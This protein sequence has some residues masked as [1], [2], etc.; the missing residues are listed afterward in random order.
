MSAPTG[1]RHRSLSG[2][3]AAACLLYSGSALNVGTWSPGATPGA[4]AA[5]QALAALQVPTAVS[6]GSACVAGRD[7][8]L[9][10]APRSARPWAAALQASLVAALGA[11]GIVG[12][13]KA[14]ESDSMNRS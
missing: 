2:L 10:Q 6:S 4:T 12:S 14:V 9:Q 13:A 3:L 11:I 7:Q 8:P 1:Q 5:L